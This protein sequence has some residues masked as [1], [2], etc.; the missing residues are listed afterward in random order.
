MASGP[1]SKAKEQDSGVS[2]KRFVSQSLSFSS[3]GMPKAMM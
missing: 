1:R 3:L 2:P